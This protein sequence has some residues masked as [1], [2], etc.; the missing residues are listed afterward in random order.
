MVVIGLWLLLNTVVGNLPKRLL[1][2]VRKE[3][4]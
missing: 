3:A 2:Y 4:S 1:S